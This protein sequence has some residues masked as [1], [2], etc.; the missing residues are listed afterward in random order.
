MP[1]TLSESYEYSAVW[2]H[3]GKQIVFASD[4]YGNFEV[5]VMT[6][7][8]GEAE[9]LTFHSAPEK[10][11]N[12]SID[13]KNIIFTTSR[14]DLHTN[15]QFPSGVMA[16]LYSVPVGGGTLIRLSLL[17]LTML[18]SVRMEKNNLAR[19]ERQ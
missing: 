7:E 19:S 18:Y 14:Q 11:S 2:S 8:G 10:P 17:R 15:V 13:K 12:F 5:F 16:E 1:L 9:R 6:A 4:R 3:D